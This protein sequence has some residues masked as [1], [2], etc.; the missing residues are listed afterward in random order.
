Q[1]CGEQRHYVGLP[2]PYLPFEIG[3]WLHKAVGFIDKS[4]PDI[5]IGDA[6][7]AGRIAIERIQKRRVNGRL[8][9]T[10]HRQPHPQHWHPLGL[11][12]A[13]HLVDLF[14]VEFDPAFLAKFME[15]IWR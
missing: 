7:L 13:D 15:A 9:A 10:Y 3:A 2:P 12:Y 4:V 8:G 11:K 5:N 6:G 14:P 1:A